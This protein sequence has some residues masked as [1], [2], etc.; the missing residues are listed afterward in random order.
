MQ[1][2]WVVDSNHTLYAPKAAHKLSP[3]KLVHMEWD[4]LENIDSGI[5]ES[6]QGLST[7]SLVYT[8]REGSHP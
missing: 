6:R 1:H 5:N 2:M 3:T 7:N 4:A 8:T